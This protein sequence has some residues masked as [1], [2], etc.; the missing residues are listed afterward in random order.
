MNYD[1]LADWQLNIYCN[2]NCPYCYIQNKKKQDP[3]YAGHDPKMIVKAFNDTKLTW[4]IHMSG[5]E[6]FLHPD[7]VN[8]CKEL[9]KKHYISINT[10]LSI[11]NVLDFAKEID[12]K[13]VAFIHCSLHIGER[14]RLKLINKFIEYY[15]VL[16]KAGFNIYTTQVMFP[17]ILHKFDETFGFFKNKKIIVRPK[18]FRGYYNLKH[19]PKAYIPAERTKL[20][21]YYNLSRKLEEISTLHI[22]PNLDDRLIYGDLSFR[23]LK[24]S[25]GKD[26]VVI[27]YNGDVI[28]CHSERKKLGNIFEGKLN[29]HKEAKPCG[30]KICV[31]PYY[32][33]R[34]AEKNYEI[35]NDDTIKKRIKHIAR[36]VIK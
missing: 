31:C 19:Y 25:A 13:R 6:P 28:R 12:P 24:C 22:D 7:F 15:H 4:L 17:P 32:G 1:I 26:F 3:R 5:G 2:F 30:A 35:T 10:N 8:M 18:I 23:G 16:K 29:L 20:L 27:E 36:K 11:P 33:L 34:Y 14:E 9:T 21:F